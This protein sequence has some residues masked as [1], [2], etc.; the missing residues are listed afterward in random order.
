MTSQ[1]PSLVDDAF[2]RSY[3]EAHDPVRVIDRGFYFAKLLNCAIRDRSPETFIELGGYP[4]HFGIYARKYLGL[5]ATILDRF[6]DRAV[7]DRLLECNGLSVGDLSTIEGDLFDNVVDRRYDLVVS[8]G[9]V[10]HF[11][12]VDAVLRRHVACLAPGGT[13]VVTVPN[14][15]GINGLLQ[16][17]FDPAHL[18]AHNRAVMDPRVLAAAAE[19]CGLVSVR[20][21]YFGAFRVWL[22][23]IGRRPLTVRLLVYAIQALG[24]PLDLIR[25]RGRLTSPHIALVA[26]A[27]Q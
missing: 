20:A 13:L 15:R 27:P 1:P 8:A 10:E 16:S 3:W 17:R 24:L 23:D 18:A 6:I 9:L 22:E 14:Y 25:V 12:D 4:G 11:D 7:I 21:G 5:E 2:W 26:H 19:R